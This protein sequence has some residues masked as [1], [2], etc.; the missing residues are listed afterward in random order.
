MTTYTYCPECATKLVIYKDNYPT[1]P[2]GHFTRYPTPVA[3][4]LALIRNND[5]YLI[6][7]RAQAPRKGFWD[8]PGGFV[9]PGESALDTLAREIKEE[10]RLVV[11]PVTYLGTYPS[12]YGET[13]NHTLATSYLFESK[14]REVTL[15]EE[16]NEYVWCRLED[17]PE[18]AFID[19]E[20]AVKDL[21]K[22]LAA[23]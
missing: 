18:L 12:V 3:A 9:E 10:T 8:L 2:T 23:K 17:M 11:D 13:G 15:S 20:N 19:C 7:K 21:K 4:T 16:N 5:E 14:T 6:I 1:C 22:L